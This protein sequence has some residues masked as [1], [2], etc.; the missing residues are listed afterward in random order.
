[1][2]IQGAWH[3]VRLL[4]LYLKCPFWAKLV[5]NKYKYITIKYL[6]FIGGLN[7]IT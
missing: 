2:T 5:L 7:L 4:F 6:R 3:Y 1:M